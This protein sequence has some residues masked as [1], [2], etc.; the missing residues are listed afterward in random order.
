MK[1]KIAGITVAVL[2]LAGLL[3]AASAA[4]RAS[5]VRPDK[6]TIEAEARKIRQN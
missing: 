4:S 3:S 1:A 2:L 5:R 6:A